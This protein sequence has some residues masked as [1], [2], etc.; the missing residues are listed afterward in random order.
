LSAD[1]GAKEVRIKA[2]MANDEL[3]IS[4]RKTG[5]RYEYRVTTPDWSFILT[6]VTEGAAGNGERMA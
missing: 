5:K 4:D 6:D 3:L 1:A 2:K